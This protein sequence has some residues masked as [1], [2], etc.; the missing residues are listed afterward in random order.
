MT[1]ST[2]TNCNRRRFLG[3]VGALGLTP[4]LLTAGEQDFSLVNKTGFTI[5]SLHISPH[6]S[7][8]WGEDILG[9]DTLGDGETLN[10]TFHRKEKAAMWDL[11]VE[12][13][14]GKS[15]TWEKLNL[16]EISEVTLFYRK[17]V[18]TATFK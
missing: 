8:E 6:S 4:A 3:L 2:T 16:L 5:D 10:I 14:D 9:K 12:D 18:A 11:R 15:F 7:D 17:G 1:T 13:S